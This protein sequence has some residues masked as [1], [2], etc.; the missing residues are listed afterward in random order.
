[1]GCFSNG[2]Y[3]SCSLETSHSSLEISCDIHINRIRDR[4]QFAS[5][6]D[7]ISSE[8]LFGS[9]RLGELERGLYGQYLFCNLINI[10]NMLQRLKLYVKT[11]YPN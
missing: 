4:R 9:L 5:L 8:E 6:Y 11:R 2:G 3:G 1:M 7:D 10:K